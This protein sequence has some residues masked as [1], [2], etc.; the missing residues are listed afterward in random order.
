VTCRWLALFT[1][2][3]TCK[4]AVIRSTLTLCRTLASNNQADLSTTP[5][6]THLTL[7]LDLTTTHHYNLTTSLATHFLSLH[8]AIRAC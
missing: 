3:I 5:T 4:L 1:T 6:S 7:D 2:T 8:N